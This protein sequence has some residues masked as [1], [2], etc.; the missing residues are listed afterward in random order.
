MVIEL[1]NPIGDYSPMVIRKHLT[2]A[3]AALMIVAFALPWFVLV[4]F[5]VMDPDHFMPSANTVS[6]YEIHRYGLAFA[7]GGNLG[8]V[9]ALVRQETPIGYYAA[10]LIPAAALLSLLMALVASGFRIVNLFAGVIPLVLLGFLI[11]V[12]GLD[13]IDHFTWGAYLTILAALGLIVSIFT[14]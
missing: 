11:S 7:A 6:G 13:I 14:P 10:Y 9:K 1:K 12:H 8:I 4:K 3:F 2:R 5:D